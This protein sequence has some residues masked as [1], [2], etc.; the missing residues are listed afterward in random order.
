MEQKEADSHQEHSSSHSTH[1]SHDMHHS[2]GHDHSSHHGH[3]LPETVLEAIRT[4]RSIRKYLDKPLPREL[5]TKVIDA[6]RYAP[7]SGNLQNWKF[8]LV[9]KPHL[10]NAIADACLQQWWIASAPHLIVIVGENDKAKRFYGDRG[11]RLYTVQ[12]AASAATCMILAAHSIGLGACWV[13]AF[14]E[15]KV[16]KL[17]FVPEENR[18]QAV[19]TLGYP[20]EHPPEPAKYPIEIN[21]YFNGWRA[22][23]ED[24]DAYY[25]FHSV[26]VHEGLR[27]L[28]GKLDSSLKKITE[29]G[30][31]MVD[32]LYKEKED[33]S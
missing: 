3:H 28:K 6:G 16:A 32:K 26:K 25:G 2:Q 1:G 20:D 8:I 31:D 21:C 27:N 22:R 5:V 19:I 12:N 9:E 7:S 29:K 4:R 14:D 11:E 17:L 10:R 30:K 33:N 23:I 13:G 24:A 15:Q 18:V